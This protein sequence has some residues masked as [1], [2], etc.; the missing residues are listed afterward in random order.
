M[1]ILKLREWA[2]PTPTEGEATMIRVTR[3]DGNPLM[4]NAEWIQS[5]EMTPD[6]LITLT[7]GYKLLVRDRL[8]EVVAAFHEYKRTQTRPPAVYS[9]EEES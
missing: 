6:T 3:L 8:E 2:F 4:L 7:T 9:E 1:P 5:I